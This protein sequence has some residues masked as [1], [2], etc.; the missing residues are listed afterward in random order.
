[1][2]LGHEHACRGDCLSVGGIACRSQSSTVSTRC[3]TQLSVMPMATLR[4]YCRAEG[5]LAIVAL[6]GSAL[7]LIAPANAERMPDEIQRS[8]AICA[9]DG[10]QGLNHQKGPPEPSG[11]ASVDSQCDTPDT[12]YG[13]D[14]GRAV[15][16]GTPRSACSL[17]GVQHSQ[18]RGVAECQRI[19]GVGSRAPPSA[20]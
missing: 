13:W 19:G 6:L 10:P 4:R 2:N 8:I 7:A 1:M 11:P 5:C 20:L 15:A 12:P 14:V 3:A 9:V 18:A 17:Y 16:L